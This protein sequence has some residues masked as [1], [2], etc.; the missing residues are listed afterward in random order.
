MERPKAPVRGSHANERARLDG[1][2]LA[3]EIRAELA[4]RMSRFTAEQKRSPGL[5]V[6]LAGTNDAS[7]IY[8]RHKI[9]TT[10]E[11][12]CYAEL[13]RLCCDGQSG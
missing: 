9:K 8:V 10:A 3:A 5:A 11:A 6:V 12:G 13:V 1:A 4:P 2:A 7:E